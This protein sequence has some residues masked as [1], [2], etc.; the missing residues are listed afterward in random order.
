VSVQF[1]F[2]ISEELRTRL[3]QAADARGASLNSEIS[4]RLEASFEGEDQAGGPGV[5]E[6]V[7]LWHA[8]FL[9]GLGLGAR[10]IGVN[11]LDAALR[12]PFVYRA[13]QLAG[14]DALDAVQP[15]P[16]VEISPEDLAEFRRLNDVFARL[17]LQG[18]AI[19]VGRK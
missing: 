4:R 5:Q 17:T 16:D 18:A 9:R 6:V 12:D 3:Q 14:N 11:D 19:K 1:K 7:K 10:A 2:R 15:K 13:G 8:A